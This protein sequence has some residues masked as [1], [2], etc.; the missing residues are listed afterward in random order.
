MSQAAAEGCGPRALGEVRG[1]AEPP[2]APL[3]RMSEFAPSLHPARASR[4][5]V[6]FSPRHLRTLSLAAAV[7]CAALGPWRAAADEEVD[8]LAALGPSMFT[9]DG[10]VYVAAAPEAAGAP[11]LKRAQALAAETGLGTRLAVEL[12]REKL[13]GQARVAERLPASVAV[14]FWPFLEYV[15]RE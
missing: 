4:P 13:Q 12:L 11:A 6:L 5:S 15:F 14:Q 1:G 9:P 7:A 10:T 2:P 8:P 3:A